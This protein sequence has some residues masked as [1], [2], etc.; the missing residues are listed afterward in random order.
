MKEFSPGLAWARKF[1]ERA[2]NDL[3]SHGKIGKIKA[4]VAYLA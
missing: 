2:G 3:G 1:G 4:S